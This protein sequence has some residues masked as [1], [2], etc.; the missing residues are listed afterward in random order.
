MLKS[1]VYTSIFVATKV[2][3]KLKYIF[4][5]LYLYTLFVNEVFT[6]ETYEMMHLFFKHLKII[7]T[8]HTCISLVSVCTEAI[9]VLLIAYN[10]AV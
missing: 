2:Q 6:L 1:T 7:V 10:G 5:I 4:L 8:L 9:R 3:A